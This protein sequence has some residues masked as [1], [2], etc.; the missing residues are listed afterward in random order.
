[1]PCLQVRNEDPEAGAQ[2]RHMT[3]RGLGQEDPAPDFD[4]GWLQVKPRDY[5]ASARGVVLTLPPRQLALLA[6][7][8]RE[9]GRV[10]TRS[11]LYAAVW[12]GDES[13]VGRVVD[14]TVAHLRARLAEVLPGRAY[15]HTHPRIGYRFS[16]E[17]AEPVEGQ[18][19]GA[20]SAG[21]GIRSSSAG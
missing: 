21:S 14:V 8:A 20:A 10:R 4:D 12:E 17:P 2:D 11:E 3:Q 7:L 15:I 1:M 6:E 16:G 19:A 13:A 18:P 9:P 5:I